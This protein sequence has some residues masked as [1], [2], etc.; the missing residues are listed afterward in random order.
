MLKYA[1]IAFGGGAGSL[2]RYLVQGWAQRMTRG[3]F[4]LGTLIVNVVGCFAIGYL[5]MLFTTRWPI[6][7]EYRVGLL[8]GVLGGFTTFSA[9]GWE[10]FSLAND[11]Q[12]LR[13]ML[14]LLLSVGLGW[15]AVWI[16]CRVAERSFG[17]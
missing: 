14:N 1:L 11:G 6:R 13:A 10:T 4:P 2:L 3:T 12:A 16:G 5:N 7:M 9:F 17:V 15:A 8:V